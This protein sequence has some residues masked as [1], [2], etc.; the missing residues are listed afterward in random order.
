MSLF[1]V[2]VV[3]LVVSLIVLRVGLLTGPRCRREPMLPM[4]PTR[5]GGDK[6]HNCRAAGHRWL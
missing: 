4:L 1:V 3:L 2:L 5:L 6:R